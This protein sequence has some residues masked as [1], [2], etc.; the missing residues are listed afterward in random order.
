[1]D[2][3]HYNSYDELESKAAELGLH[4]PH[5]DNVKEVFARKVKVEGS[6]IETKN[7]LAIHPMEGFDGELNG[8]PSELT[9]RRYK[10]FASGGAGLFWFEATAVCPESRSSKRQLYINDETVEEYKKLAETMHELSGGAPIIMQLT[11][12]GRFSRP[13]NVPAPIISYHNPVMNTKFNIDPSY[14]V[15]TDEYFDTIP[16]MY[17]KAAKLAK[18]AGFDG[19]DVKCCHKYLF[20]ELLSAYNREGK[21]G[22]SFENRTRLLKDSIEAAKQWADDDFIIASRVAPYDVL[23]YPWGFGA[24]HEDYLKPNLEESFELI[25]LLHD[26]GIRLINLTYGSPY[27]NPHV[28]RP[29]DMGGYEA[30]EHQLTGVARMIDN[31]AKY[32]EKFPDIR[33]MATGYTY[34]RGLAPEVGAGAL[35]NG[36]ADIIG[37]GRMAFANPSFASQILETGRIDASSACLTCSKCTELMRAFTTTGCVIRDSDVYMPLYRENCMK[38]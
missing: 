7:S 28:N 23:P 27:I 11:H 30:P 37:F 34:L 20:S 3:F 9:W 15:A 22:G 1:M 6:N 24:D 12:S 25:K 36:M 33:F 16:D 4:F 17:A 21:Y 8:A 14:P 19:V 5:S 26:E 35:E 38:K 31:T 29:Y 32:K 2:K 10:R 18:D 13:T